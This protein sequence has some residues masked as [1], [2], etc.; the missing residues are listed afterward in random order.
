MYQTVLPFGGNSAKMG[1]TSSPEMN[2]GLYDRAPACH[3][4]PAYPA[5]RQA[6]GRLAG[7]A[8]KPVELKYYY[9]GKKDDS[10]GTG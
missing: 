8:G 7:E 6:D 9:Y 3:D 2:P 5:Y 1:I 10:T 4:C